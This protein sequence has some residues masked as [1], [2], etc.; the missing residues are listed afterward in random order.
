LV[1]VAAYDAGG[2][3]DFEAV[4]LYGFVFAWG[5]GASEVCLEAGDEFVGAKWF[6]DVV[7][8]AGVKCADLLGLVVVG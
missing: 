8:G 5:V 7:V 6:G 4:E 3:V 2:E 1:A